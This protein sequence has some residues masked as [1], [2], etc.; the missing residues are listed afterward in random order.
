MTD[1]VTPLAQIQVKVILM[2]VIVLRRQHDVKH[3]LLVEPLHRWLS[4]ARWG[5]STLSAS[6]LTLATVVLVLGPLTALGAAFATEAADLLRRSGYRIFHTSRRG[7][8]FSL[9]RT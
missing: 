1:E 5:G 8:E 6:L 9:L 3:K 4:R 2:R 7:L